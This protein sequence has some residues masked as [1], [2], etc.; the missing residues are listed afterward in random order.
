MYAWRHIPIVRI[1]IPFIAGI[2]SSGYLQVPILYIT[3]GLVFAL[4]ILIS[5]HYYLKFN[6]N[7]KVQR[8]LSV[9]ILFSY[10]LLG[11]MITSFHNEE[12]YASH[13]SNFQDK[14]GELVVRVINQPEQK[15]KSVGC[16]V[17][18]CQ[19]QGVSEVLSVKGKAQLY[20]VK[21]SSSSKIKYGDYLVLGKSISPISEPKNPYQFDFKQ[22]YANQ[23]IYHQEF[24]DSTSWAFLGSN[25]TSLIWQFSY[26][27]RDYLKQRFITLFPNQD[28]R[29][30]AEALV[31]GYK[32]DL[33]KEWLKAF[34]RTGTIHVLAVSGLH[35]G[36]I[37]LLLNLILGVSKS[38]GRVLIF[39]SIIITL[40]LFFYCL[41]TGFAPSVSRATIMFSTVVVAK[42][43]NRQSNIY[44]TLALSAFVLLVID[45]YNLFQVGFQFS[46][47]AVLGIVH[48]KDI[49][50]SWIPAKSWLQDKVASLL[51]VS[52]AAQITTFPLGLYYFHQYPNLF[53]ISNLIV[54]PCI[55]VILYCSLLAIGVSIF[56][57]IVSEAFS[58]LASVYIEFVSRIVH[59]IQDIPYAFFDGVHISFA[60]MILLYCFVITITITL[61]FKVVRGWWFVVGTVI[62]F[63][64][65]DLRYE[66]KLNKDEVVVFHVRNQTLVGLKSQ[67]KLTVLASS[68]SY[69]Q[70]N[71]Y[72]FILEPYAINARIDKEFKIIPLGLSKSKQ[73]IGDVQF[74][75]N[76][77]LWHRSKSYLFLDYVQEYVS[78]TLSVDVLLVGGRKSKNY[79]E[80]VLPL[81]KSEKTIFLDHWENDDFNSKTDSTEVLQSRYIVIT[82][83]I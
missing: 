47:L 26:K 44:N 8:G 68:S 37:F 12:N 39:K 46:Y 24:V 35:V 72:D 79:L 55:T 75:G 56:S 10:F 23:N 78:D 4:L 40:C 61:K 22:Y 59:V 82:S 9:L 3:Q 80:K 31:F 48:Y 34:S 14:E 43:F 29:G 67:E 30:V 77:I 25:K 51:A 74:G 32:D 42:A 70:S 13:Y 69:K 6:I 19:L 28:I 83:N 7:L 45:P 63:L 11:I 65:Y 38:T 33:N 73:L 15:Q 76:G 18:L 62:L 58:N 17:E 20:F 81:I 66:N 57:D 53:F 50:R 27:I 5:V 54:I 49:F 21:S 71:T 1:L 64:I 36:I 60:Q 41:L 52:V 2:I 16:A